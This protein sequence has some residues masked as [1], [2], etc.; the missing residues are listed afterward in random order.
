MSFF[1]FLLA[2]LFS[3]YLGIDKEFIDLIYK[4]VIF[5]I[6]LELIY[7]MFFFGAIW[8]GFEMLASL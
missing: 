4:I 5:V 7:W 1:L 6:I 8:Y 3:I 2:W